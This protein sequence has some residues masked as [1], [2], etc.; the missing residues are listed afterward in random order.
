MRKLLYLLLALVFVFTF[1]IGLKHSS[2][3]AM[4]DLVT[5][6]AFDDDDDIPEIVF[7]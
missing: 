7:L 5:I 4:N 3:N 6:N 1:L 2:K